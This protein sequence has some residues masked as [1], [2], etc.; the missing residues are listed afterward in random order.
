[1]ETIEFRYLIHIKNVQNT[2]HKLVLQTTIETVITL[3]GF[4]RKSF[5][6]ERLEL[7]ATRKDLKSTDY[8]MNIS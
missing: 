5:P 6:A 2:Q 8:V 3:M 7:N 1:M 4:H